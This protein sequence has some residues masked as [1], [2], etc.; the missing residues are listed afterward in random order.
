MGMVLERCISEDLNRK[1][2]NSWQD[3]PKNRYKQLLTGAL[4]DGEVR[5][6]LLLLICVFKIAFKFTWNSLLTDFPPLPDDPP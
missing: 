1:M 4:M 3:E 6:V 2:A 5:A